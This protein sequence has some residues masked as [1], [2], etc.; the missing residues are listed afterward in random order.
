MA[1]I[2]GAGYMNQSVYLAAGSYNLSFEAAQCVNAQTASQ[3]IQVTV[4]GHQVGLVTP[5]GSTYSLY[6]TSNFTVAAGTHTIQ[7]NGMNPSGGVNA[8]L[9]DLVS[10]G[11]VQDQIVDGNF[12]APTLAANS[13]VVEP[14]GAPWQFS[15]SAGVS[16]N[17]S[18]LTSGNPAAPQGTQVGYISS[19]G[20]MSYSVYL[21][22][23]TYNLSFM[24]AQRAK[25]QTQNQEIQVLVDNAQVG[26]ILPSSTS[27]TPVQTANFTVAAGTHTIQFVGL[28]PQ[29]A[30]STAFIDEVSVSAA[31]NSLSDGGFESPVLAAHTY[32]AAPSG[33]GWQFSGAAGVTT[34]G[35][36][37]TLGSANA[38]DGNQVAY[39]KDNAVM[40]QSVSFA[41]GTYDI[42]FLATQRADYQTQNQT[43]RVLVNG[44][45]VGLITPSGTKY[46]LY[47]T[48]NFTVPAGTYAVQFVGMAPAAAD[49]TAFIDDAA[50]NNGCA[51]S[52][53]SFEQPALAAGAYAVDPGGSSWQFFGDAGVSSNNSAFT[54]G[55]PSA[56]RQPGGLHQEQR[57]HQPIGLPYRRVLQYLLHGGPARQIADPVSGTGDPGR[58]Q[59]G[60]HGHSDRHD[61]R[62][63]PD[64]EFHRGQGR[65]A[66]DPVPRLEPQGRQ[67]QHRLHRWSAVERLRT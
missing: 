2:Q 21:D 62:P 47:Q 43:I 34:N 30:D 25:Y 31:E 16:T 66:Y 53:G 42:S 11:T 44:A 56:G 32:Q 28:S 8:A 24:A 35:S 3:Q 46:L 64:A 52:E 50:I 18:S 6:E 14:S 10:L 38:P 33:S 22:A 20:S 26:V 51:I 55:N 1:V 36:A 17:G 37:F 39:L 49:S 40:S 67:R 23:N 45:Q 58:R 63:V 57:Q 48:S 7:F 29:S 15:G 61:V 13:Y 41:A 4:D 5:L 60:R 12:Q 27:Y 59:R 54:T 65:L 9:I 19:N